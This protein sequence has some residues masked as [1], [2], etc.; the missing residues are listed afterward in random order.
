[1]RTILAGLLMLPAVLLAPAAVSA[2]PGSVKPQVVLLHGLARGAASMQPMARALEQD[3]Y[4]VCNLGYP[5]REHSIDALAREHVAPQIARCFPQRAGALHF[6]THSM[7]GII[8]REL[9]RTGAAGPIGR[10]VMLGPPNQ[11]SEVVDRL[12]D[13]RLFQALNG[14]AGGELGTAGDSAPQRLGPARFEL[15]IIAGNRSINWMLSLLIPGPDDGK[16]AV[17]R[18][19]LEGMQDFVV[20]R[21]S[22]PFIMQSPQAIAQT[23]AFL[24]QGRFLHEPAASTVPVSSYERRRDLAVAGAAPRKAAISSSQYGE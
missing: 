7:G 20:L 8:V 10:V 23:L 21:A 13:W 14:P 11:G 1:M 4:A 5:S 2:P 17:A 9:A 22:H 19:G 15:G 12:G 18:A 16:V 24:R 6:V 3:G